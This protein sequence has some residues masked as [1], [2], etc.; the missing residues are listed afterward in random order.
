VKCLRVYGFCNVWLCAFVGFVMFGCFDN[1]VV[2]F[3][4]CVV[5]FTVFWIVSFMYIYS[6]FFLSVLV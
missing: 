2:I 4:I 3:V 5:V 6:D 1:C